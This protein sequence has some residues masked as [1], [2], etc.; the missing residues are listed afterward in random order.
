MDNN[1]VI[2]ESGQTIRRAPGIS[3]EDYSDTHP[4]GPPVLDPAG[5]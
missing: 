4:A 2:I 1:Q 5:R 3:K